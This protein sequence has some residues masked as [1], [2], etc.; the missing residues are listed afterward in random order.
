MK[1]IL[2]LEEN[3]HQVEKVGN[4]MLLRKKRTDAELFKELRIMN[5]IFG[6]TAITIAVVGFFW[7]D[8]GF[9]YNMALFFIG[10]MLITY[11]GQRFLQ[12]HPKVITA[13]IFILLALAIAGFVMFWMFNW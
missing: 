11:A 9:F 10:L 6:L 2:L 8:L 4:K 3:P 5:F 1:E 7:K 12:K 13:L